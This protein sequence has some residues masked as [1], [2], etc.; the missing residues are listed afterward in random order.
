MGC[1][2]LLDEHLKPYL[3]EMNTNP[4]LFTG[5]IFIINP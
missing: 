2:I 3:L 5:Y 4:A 1:D